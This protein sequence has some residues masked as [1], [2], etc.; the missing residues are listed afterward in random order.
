MEFLKKGDYQS[1]GHGATLC[2]SPVALTFQLYIF[3]GIY[4]RIRSTFSPEPRFDVQ[5]LYSITFDSL[6]K[7]STCSCDFASSNM[8]LAV[9]IPSH[10]LYDLSFHVM[11]STSHVT[12]LRTICQCPFLSY[13]DVC[14]VYPRSRS[15]HSIVHPS[16]VYLAQIRNFSCFSSFSSNPTIFRTINRFDG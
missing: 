11:H 3:Q 10:V 9:L 1:L 13:N 12:S 5:C 4:N 2:G 16:I 8:P 6:L 7:Y 14:D 15:N